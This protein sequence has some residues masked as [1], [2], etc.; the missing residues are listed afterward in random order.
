MSAEPLLARLPQSLRSNRLLLSERE[1][2]AGARVTTTANAAVLARPGPTGDV[3]MCVGDPDG[4]LDLLDG[5]ARLAYRAQSVGAGWLSA[6]RSAALPASM[7]D[8]LRLV[9]GPTWDWRALET[10][11]LDTSL[12]A[13][14]VTRA[15][16]LGGVIELDREAEAEAIRSVLREGNPRSTG[17]PLDAGEVAWYGVRSHGALVAVIGVTQLLGRPEGGSDAS[18]HLH[19]LTVLPR[20]A[21]RGL[22]T[23]LLA[24][25]MLAARGRGAD[26]V[27][28][29]LY[30]DNA[31]ARG[32]Y[33]RLGF[34]VVAQMASFAPT[35]RG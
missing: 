15:E 34:D 17:D 20:V 21:G 31:R 16:A 11:E 14:C 4:V 33:D 25:A 29:G 13:A 1:D 3:L 32:I 19:G 5:E 12:L 7:L 18:W 23:A 30:A 10:G 8:A 26:W 24:T 35:R 6:P 22:G 2:W 9:P 28:L 27:S